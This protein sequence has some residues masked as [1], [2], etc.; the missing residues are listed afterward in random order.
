MR[1][2][3]ASRSGGISHSD[4]LMIYNSL[5]PL[6][7]RSLSLTWPCSIMVYVAAFVLGDPIF[8]ARVTSVVYVITLELVITRG[9]RIKVARPQRH[10]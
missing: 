4:L 6:G 1:G 7:I 5:T 3:T 2:E 10:Y 9:A 8:T